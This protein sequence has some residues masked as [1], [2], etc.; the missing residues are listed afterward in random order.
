MEEKRDIVVEEDATFKSNVRRMLAARKIKR[1]VPMLIWLRSQK[2]LKVDAN[3]RRASIA[4]H[5]MVLLEEMIAEEEEV[6]P[7]GS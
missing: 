4:Q 2:Q 1:V 5:E 6:H 3:D 7:D